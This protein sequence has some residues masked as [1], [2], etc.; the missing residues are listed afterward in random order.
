MIPQRRPGQAMEEHK[1]EMA[2]WLGY[3]SVEAMDREHDDLHRSLCDLLGVTSH[4]MACAEG[5]P[6]NPKL[7]GMEEDAVLYAQRLKGHHG[8]VE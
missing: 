8:W 5:K 4:S 3:P 6:F 2:A 7:A 1:A